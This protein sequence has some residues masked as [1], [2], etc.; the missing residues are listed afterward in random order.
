MAFN[1]SGTHVRIHDWTTDLANLVPVTASRM[2]AEN[3]DIS[4]SLSNVICR[5][6]Q[7]T[8]TARIPFASG[9][10]AAAGSI[11]A[12]SYAQTNDNNT[13][14]YFPAA[15]QLG[16]TAGG[17]AI[18]TSTSALVSIPVAMSLALTLAVTGNTTLS[19]ALAVTGN[20]TVGGTLGVTGAST[21]TGAVTVPNDSFTY[22]K[23]QNTAGG[24]VLLGRPS[25]G[26][27]DLG[28]I[29]CT[30]AGRDL[31]DDAAPSNQRTTLG[32]GTVATFDTGTS[33]ATIGRLDGN[34]TYSGTATF[35][36]AFSASGVSAFT[37]TGGVAAR[38]T[39]KAFG[40]VVNSALV[41]GS[42]NISGLVDNGITHTL[43]FT[44]GLSTSDYAVVLT[45]DRQ[46]AD[47]TLNISYTSRGTT[48]FTVGGDVGGT[49]VDPDSYSFV[50]LENS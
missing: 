21:F 41:S 44:T 16:L 37:G 6:G 45:V 8:T 36:A 7:S 48:G 17:T 2:D 25:T 31:L 22:A 18:L 29:T 1:G 4:T 35:S 49:D 15:D 9:V 50:V 20:A 13:G 12:A 43:S 24:D 10:S 30:A 38:N 26:A 47:R 28:E 5:D 39:V 23:L 27:G 46:S 42:F 3:D 14:L 32:L 34:N 40:T 33:G 11:S 19:A